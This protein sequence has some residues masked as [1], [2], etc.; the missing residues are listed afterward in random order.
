MDALA[1]DP[2]AAVKAIAAKIQEDVKESGLD[3]AEAFVDKLEDLKE[4]AKNGPGDLMD[5]VKDIMASFKEK[6]D[7]A[8]A[9]PASL[10]PGGGSLAA[11]ATWYGNAV[12]EKLKALA[13]EFQE[14]F[15]AMQSVAKEMAGPF[16][17]LGK[18]MGEAMD[19]INKAVKGLTSLPKELTSLADNVKGADDL[20]DVDT[21]K[22]KSA[23]DTSAMDGSLDSLAGL[24]D[25]MG[26][27]VT[28]MKGGVEKVKDF[29]G[30][31]PDTIK[32]AFQV[33]T[34]LCF[35]T[36]C[37]MD[38]APAIMKDLLD[39]VKAL[40]EFNFGPVIDMLEGLKENV[41][42]LDVSKVKD[43][44]AKFSEMAQGNIENLD[45]AVNAAK[46][47]GSIPGLGGGAPK[48]PW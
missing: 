2:A 46:L 33:P 39:K 43:P 25:T 28:T 21:G 1:G 31:A 47:A 3:V 37:A 27:L 17:E 41:G 23:L 40:G 36:S 11:C 48:L 8:L 45:K 26:P 20:K 19:G 42:N 18:T 29:V 16:K 13:A 6:L 44:V 35:M 24:K 14:L 4:Q 7:A 5:K 9:N 22:M 12:C 34:P 32:G 38:Q 15:D 30:S 10:A